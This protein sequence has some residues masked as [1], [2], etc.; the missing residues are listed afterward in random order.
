M[1]QYLVAI[2]AVLVLINLGLTIA[3]LL[4]H[5]PSTPQNLDDRFGSLEKGLERTDRLVRDEI[6]KNREE[7]AALARMGR[8]EVSRVLK[9]DSQNLLSRLAENTTWQKNQFD[10]FSSNLRTLTE[11]N[12][13]RLEKMRETVE[14]K[15]T[16]L[17][18]S[19]ERSNAANRDEVTKSLK[20]F[21]ET[22][23]ARMKEHAA[24]QDRQLVAVASS[25]KTL[26]D[27]NAQ[28][29]QKLREVV[30][31]QLKELQ[32]DN[33]QQLE[34]MRATVDEKLHATLE[35]RL[36]ESFKSVSERLDSVR[37]G[38]GA[39]QALA[40]G[41]GDLKKVLANIKTRGGWGEIQ[42]GNLLE[43]LLSPDQYEAN[44]A[45]NPHTDLRVEYAIKLPGG[46]DSG[47][48]PLWLP[49]DAKFPLEDY[50]RLL[51]AQEESDLP[52]VEKAA[53][54][55]ETRIRLEAKSIRE[56]YISPPHTTNFAILFLPVEGLY[57][58]VLRQP[59]LADALQRDSQVVVMGPTTLGAIL[60]ALQMGFR[61]L[62]IQKRS[63][64]VWQV[65]GAVKTEFGKFG[66]LLDRVEKKL[67]EASDTISK[68]QTRT[69]Q[70]ERKLKDVQE[71]PPEDSA[72]LLGPVEVVATEAV[73]E[74]NSPV[75][76]TSG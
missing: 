68:A 18:E 47:N 61:T 53:K 59:G 74:E 43:Q 65:L 69:R 71:L 49:I 24:Q 6:A 3:V 9:D 39:M 34:Q 22:L 7:A 54:A 42:L 30:E 13:Q 56:K 52:K 51:D 11:T 37:E 66:D 73:E 25:L 38:L 8:E 29:L 21:S 41:V 35:R 15:L 62:A 76:P 70:M 44:V 58:E 1:S 45:P 32:K 63:S 4:F 20:E 27:T 17:Q 50:Q 46:E 57:A 5:K 40:A 55:L 33:A 36:S 26:T 48:A 75:E 67:H 10:S 12:E 31:G 19:A 64:E 16:A 14:Q 23:L 72:K 60:N 2:L 28:E